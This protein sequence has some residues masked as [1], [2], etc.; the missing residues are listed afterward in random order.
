MKS[1]LRL[2]FVLPLAVIAVLGLAV[3]QFGLLDRLTG[4]DGDASATPSE[5]QQATDTVPTEPTGQ[6][7]PAPTTTGDTAQGAEEPADSKPTGMEQLEK[8][9]RKHDV[10][11]VVVYTPDSA[12]DTRQ[13]GEARAGADDAKAGFL[14]LNGTNDNQIAEL[15]EKYDIRTT[16]AVLVFTKGMVLLTNITGFADG[17]IVAQAAQNAGE[18][19]T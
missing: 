11:V 16:P 14:A 17:E 4:S 10:V 6:D 9:L 5:T 15:A 18:L 19:S 1:K 3:S 13:I 7:E 8:Q 12:V 2:R